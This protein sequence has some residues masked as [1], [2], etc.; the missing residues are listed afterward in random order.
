MLRS[1]SGQFALYA[2]LLFLV[3]GVGVASWNL[4]SYQRYGEEVEQ[5]L[6][7]GLAAH[8]VYDNKQLKQ[9]E[10]DAGKL[11][12]AFHTMMLLGPDWE[13]YALDKKGR[14]LAYSAPPGKVKRQQISLAP[15]QAF[16]E[17]ADFPLYGDD[18][19]SAD[20]QRIFSVAP[21][22]DTA[23]Q[24]T[25]YLYVIIG[26]EQW[27]DLSAMLATSRVLQ[28]SWRLL[29]AALLFGLMLL[30]LLFILLTR[31]LRHLVRRFDQFVDD[32]FSRG[33]DQPI[34][35]KPWTP[36]EVVSLNRAFDEM[37]GHIEKQLTQ[38]KSTE[39]LRR[40]LLSHVSHDFRTPLASLQGYLETWL[41]QQPEKR[42]PELVQV[43]L[44]NA[45][46]LNML[47]EQLFELARLEGGDIRFNPEPVMVSELAS[48]VVQRLQL[49]AQ[50]QGVT[51]SVDT[52][53]RQLQVVADIAKLER[54][55]VNLIDN[56]LRHTPSGGDVTL[57]IE[58]A[59]DH[60]QLAVVDSGC[61]IDQAELPH[62]FD[63]HFRA[64]N[65]VNG[66]GVNTGLGLA[67][68]HQLVVLHGSEVEVESQPQQG[69]RFGFSLPLAS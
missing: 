1:L 9:G 29:G 49:L 65:S 44:K 14:L 26:G 61:G 13:I 15:V 11:K 57:K 69:S 12:D 59:N 8:M 17:G 18:P 2:T 10:I 22:E 36:S 4:S 35:P 21:I 23:G 31:P 66:N 16:F 34:P 68:V 27:Q 33:K 50:S 7:R 24:L 19:R 53:V 52:K 32:D 25:G 20:G 37:A 55:L 60:A 67:I 28:D 38:I 48:D 3:V 5:R 45:Q 62:I 54:I 64:S 43:A 40:E 6:H 47:V 56:A 39:Q 46:Q 63:P 30:M 41:L 58:A 51:L 42:Q